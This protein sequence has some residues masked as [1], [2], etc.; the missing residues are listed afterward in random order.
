MKRRMCWI[1][2]Y[3]WVWFVVAGVCSAQRYEPKWESLDARP[4]PQWW[5]DAK[6]GIFIDWGVCSVPAW[7]VRGEY[8]EWYWRRMEDDKK[9]NGPWWQYHKNT[10]GENFTYF[11]F[12]PM[13]KA[14]LFNPDQWAD[15]FR[16]SGARYVVLISKHH[17]GYCL[18]PSAEANRTWARAWNAADIGPRRDFVGDLT[19]AVRKKGI[20]MGIYYSLYEWFNPLWLTD[21][22][23][24]VEKHMIPQ[25]KDVVTRYKPSVIFSDGEWDMDSKSWRSEELLAWLFNESPVR[26]EVVIND[27]WGKG[28]RH[29]HGGYYTTEYGAGLAGAS[30]PWEENRGMAY[31]FGYSRTEFLSDYKSAR[32]LILM[33]IDLVSRGGNLL[34]DIGP[35]GDGAI[36]VIMEERLIQIGDWLNVNGEAIYGTKTWKRAIQWTEGQRPDV[37]YGGEY[38]VKYD[39]AALTGKPTTDKAAIEAFFTTKDGT[40]YVIT[41]RWPGKGLVVKDVEVS[42][43]TD[44]TLLGLA[45]SIPWDRSGS[46]LT[47]HVPILSVDEVPCQ[48]AYV[49]KV[50]HVK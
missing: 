26:D 25:F 4:T 15:I 30:H 13:F 36:P 49:F 22:A 10:Y 50:T 24:Y 43:D 38:K 42:P 12:A 6:F 37:G 1:A 41:P 17:D 39:I 27:R 45:Q 23:A 21:R 19:D 46:N 18:W 8:A 47:I 34:L 29:R 2:A 35:A 48:Y 40:L 31:S 33:L 14:E 44:V 9:E 16:R 28:T 20:R 5:V 3:W 11:D 32:E 7:S